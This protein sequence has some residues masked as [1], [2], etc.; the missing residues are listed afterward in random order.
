MKI[1]HAIREAS[2]SELRFVKQLGVDGVFVSAR[3]A[4]T[5]VEHGYATVDELAALNETVTAHRLEILNLRLD[6]WHTAHILQGKPERDREID[7]ICKT[8]RAAGQVGIPTVFYNLTPW[9]SMNRAWAEFPGVPAP[10][11]TDIRL[12]SGP[13]R[14]YRPVGRG[15]AVLL[16]HTHDLAV[17]DAAKAADSSN[18]LY[19]AVSAEEMWE[20]I[21]YFYE[22]VIPVADEAGVNVGSHPDDP[23]E[24]VY[25][26]VEQVLNS[27]EGLKKLVDLVPSPRSG[28]LLCLGTLHEMGTGPEDTMAAIEYLVQ[29][30][31]VFSAHFR[32]PR[33]TVPNGYYQEDFLDEGDLDMFAVMRLLHKHDYQGSLD[34]DHAIGLEGDDPRGRI[35]FAW[36]L[37]Y[38]RALK[39]AAQAGG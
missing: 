19:G 22:R 9:R 23:P 14:R 5:Y 12:G 7:E 28:L 16:T 33:G 26:G 6:P 34:P 31:K 1:G 27:F 2:D 30:G 4:P 38:M 36:E 37:G 35:A 39:A 20:R 17:E 18:A 29:R 15:Q 3:L 11:P 24:R 32:N 10:G 25:R 21:R 13:G 8:V